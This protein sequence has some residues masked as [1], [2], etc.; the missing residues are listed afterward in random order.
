MHSR[1]DPAA[2]GLLLAWLTLVAGTTAGAQPTV[3]SRGSIS[4]T[5]DAMAN[6]DATEL[7]VRVENTVDV[8]VSEAWAVRVGSWVDGFA[9]V[10]RGH[11]E[12]DLIYQ[13]GEIYARYRATRFRTHDAR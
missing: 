10:R 1:R 6:V 7:R 12:R 3:T 13:P 8:E 5:V 2:R 9:G 11:R 4:T